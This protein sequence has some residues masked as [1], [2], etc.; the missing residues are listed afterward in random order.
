MMI[1]F[2]RGAAT[3]PL[4]VFLLRGHALPL[5]YLTSPS[6][7]FLTYI[8]PL[9]YL[10]LLRTVQHTAPPASHLA[11][12][13]VPFPHLRAA[14]TSHPRPAGATIATLV[15]SPNPPPAYHADSMSMPALDSRGSVA[16]VEDADRLE[17]VFP[18]AREVPGQQQF[19][20]VL[21]FTAGGKY[22]GVVVSQGR[23]R[24]I[25]LVVNP[26]SGMDQMGDE[27]IMSFGSGSWVD[28]LVSAEGG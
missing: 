27:A 11:N 6:I 25:E 14:L 5:P 26:F 10:K 9:A 20:W 3:A 15:L 8:S 19:S 12:L 22:P 28:L 17:V 21:D 23:M 4:D 1:R 7:S 16:L 24:E 2:E 18:A 13:D